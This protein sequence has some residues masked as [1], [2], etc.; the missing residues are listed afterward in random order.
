MRGDM[1]L[2]LTNLRRARV[3]SA[4]VPLFL[5]SGATSLVYETLWS[6]E[7]H[8]VVG[9]SQLAI[10]IV[11]AAFMAGLALGG[12]LA[13]RLVDR[14]RR[15]LH[16]YAALEAFIGAYAL[17]FPVLVKLIEPVYVGFYQ[18]AAPGP[19]VSS[20]A[21]FLLLGLAMLPPTAAMGAT[22]PLL[23][24][25]AVVDQGEAGVVVGRLYGA[26][27]LGAVVGAGLAGFVL[28]PE[29]GLHTTTIVA[30]S[31]NFL[32]ALVAVAVG[33]DAGDL[34]LAVRAKATRGPDEGPA[35]WALA[36]I[37][38]FASLLYEVAWFRVLVL[39]L[40]GSAY[41]FTVM[42]LAFLLGIGVGGWLGGPLADLAAARGG[43]V[44]VLRWLAGV[45]VG[46]GVLA[47]GTMYA[48]GELPYAYA[49]LFTAAEGGP[50]LFWPLMLG[51]AL[52]VTLP[53]CL[54]MGA[55]FPFLVR[56]A[57]GPEAP[58]DGTGGPVGRLYGANTVGGIFGAALG[59][60]FLLPGLAVTG[61]VL[62]G[63]SANALAALLAL[64][65]AAGGLRRVVAPG[66]ALASGVVLIHLFPP[67]WN[68]L[69]M[70]AGMYKYITDMDDRSRQ[71]VWDYVVAPYDLLYYREGLSSVVTVARVRATGNVWLANNGKIDASSRADM[72]TQVLVSQLPFAFEPDA[73]QVA[74]IGLA[75]GVT[76]GSVTTQPSPERI[77]IIELEPAIVAASH[78]FD[79]LNNRPLDDSRAR[80]FANDG[81]NHLVL[82][83]DHTYD[84]IISE[85]SN[86][87]LTGVS[88]LFTADFFE[89]GK[90]KLTKGGV[91]SQWVQM[92]GMDYGDLLSLLRT[93]AST[94]P[95]VLLFSTIEDADL[96]LVGSEEPLDLDPVT[97]DRMVHASESVAI[98]LSQVKIYDGF[99]VLALFHLDR[100]GILRQSE[101]VELNTDDNMRIEYSAPR[102]LYDDTSEDN[103]LNLL[104]PHN[105][106]ATVPVSAL[107]GP[108]DHIKLAQAYVRRDDWLRAW[109]TIEPV[110]DELEHDYEAQ[111]LGVEIQE[112]LEQQLRPVKRRAKGED[113]SG[114]A[115]P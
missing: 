36:L 13:A 77:D 35:L 56:A 69:L 55:A 43:R 45:Q 25:F 34:P 20:L 8:L 105:A 52:A 57:V 33:R 3:R 89:M 63:V 74:V 67:P 22:L 54:G 15:P 91:W 53:P 9:T 94:Y 106:G 98:D 21:Q 18:S 112:E 99:D 66:A 39:T 102:H 1:D 38:G 107:T 85:P 60:F 113:A 47:W 97:F 80:L 90:R 42:L 64:S 115:T 40:G 6:R 44:S 71:G 96:V 41:A 76:A 12:V 16:A 83:P 31:A 104:H 79:D 26:N 73:K 62:L 82:T 95:H 19:L 50:D 28:L 101:G 24:R 27:T 68:P 7:L 65:V 75:S 30:A 103:F 37:A 70:T 23:A 87:W 110:L 109:L 61:S 4:L 93:F 84:I 29:L 100:D 48:Y 81:R 32:L 108:A 11:L 10:S 59:G 86:P 111:R 92:Y 14:V 88:N 114:T 2:E 51:L 17:L 72:P 58:T 5:T 78:L 49:R 46:V